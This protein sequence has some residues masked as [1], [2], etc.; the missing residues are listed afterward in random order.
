LR[1]FKITLFILFLCMV[2]WVVEA[3]LRH[4][5]SNHSLTDSSG[6]GQVAVFAIV[7]PAVLLFSWYVARIDTLQFLARYVVQ[8]RR[9]LKGFLLIFGATI[10]VCVVGYLLLAAFGNVRWSHAAWQNLRGDIVERMAVALLIVLLLATVEEMIFRAFVLRYLRYNDT[11]WVTVSAVVFSSFIFSVSHLLALIGV[12]DLVSKVPML[13]GL[14]TIG[15]LLGTTYVSTG[16]L[17]CSI[18][19][20]CGLIGFKVTLIKTNLLDLVPNWLVGGYGDIRLAPIAWLLFL[21]MTLTVVLLRRRLHEAFWVETAV[22]PDGDGEFKLPA[23]PSA[24]AA[25]AGAR[26]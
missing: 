20:H 22:C 26:P 6:P 23:Q 12:W 3:V 17:A 5:H 7:L 9:T 8:W 2:A 16:S 4:V 1:Y 21:L 10:L 19:L 24:R 13:I 11:V 18:G 14:F 25:T 15:L